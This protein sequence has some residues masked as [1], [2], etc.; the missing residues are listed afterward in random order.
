MGVRR[1]FSVGGNVEMLLILFKLLT[2]QCKWTFTKALAHFTAIITKIHFIGSNS[3]VHCDKFKLQ[4]RLS[5]DFSS[6][7][8]FYKEANCNGF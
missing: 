1:N 6:R 8:L 7:V 5:A 3:Q 4:N 2:M